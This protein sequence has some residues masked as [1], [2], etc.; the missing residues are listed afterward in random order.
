MLNQP[1]SMRHKR[2]AF[3]HN[4]FMVNI[5]QLQSTHWNLI[6]TQHR[7]VFTKVDLTSVSAVNFNKARNVKRK[8]KWDLHDVILKF[9]L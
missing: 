1:P 7:V 8:S 2:T 4:G 6:V 9:K 5:F 3:F